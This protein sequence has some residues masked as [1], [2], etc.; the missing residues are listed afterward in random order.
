ME[1]LCGMLNGKGGIVV[2]GVTNSGKIVGQEIADKTTRMVGE[3]L[4]RFEPSI[5]IQPQYLKLPD[6]DKQIIIFHAEGY[7]PD[8]PYS[9]DG[10]PYQRHDSVT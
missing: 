2:F 6:S 4:Q 1:T 7:N 9:Y 3:A 8:R 10:R 5:D